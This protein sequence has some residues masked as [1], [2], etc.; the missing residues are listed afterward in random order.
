LSEPD[1]DATASLPIGS[2]TVNEFRP[3]ERLGNRYVVVQFVA[4]GGMGEVY[5]VIDEHLQGKHIAIKTL[6]RELAS[7]PEMRARFEREVL[8]AREVTHRAVCPTWDLIR[9]DRPT[10][11]V[12]C[13]SMKL[14]RGESLSSRLRRQGPMTPDAALLIARQMAAGLDA[15]HDAGVIHRD[16]K[17]GNVILEGQGTDTAAT[18]TDFGLSRIYNSDSTIGGIGQ[19]AGTRGYIAPE[20]YAGRTASPASDV[21]GFGVVLFEMLTGQQPLDCRGEPDLSVL[22]APDGWK[23]AIAGCLVTDPRERFQSAGEAIDLLESLETRRRPAKRGRQSTARRARP[24]LLLAGAL[25]LSGALFWFAPRA[26]DILHPLPLHRFV[27]LGSAPSSDP[28][29]SAMVG[30]ILDGMHDRLVRAESQVKDVLI[31]GTAELVRNEDP[32]T[33]GANLMLSVSLGGEGTMARLQLID[34]SSHKVLRT[35]QAPID[36]FQ[37]GGAPGAAA[38]IAAKMLGIPIAAEHLKDENELAGL[39]ASSYQIFTAAEELRRQPN[40]AGLDASIEKYQRVLEVSPRFAL[41]YAK[42][43][44]AYTRK[45]QLTHDSAALS[46]AGNNAELAIRRNPESATAVLSQALVFLYSGRAPQAL[47]ALATVLRLDPAN[48]EVLLYQATAYRDL[49]RPKDEE[50]TCRLIIRER[51]NYYRAYNALGMVLY[52]AGRYRESLIAFQQATQIA[53]REAL[54]FANLGLAYSLLGSKAEASAAF[55]ASLERAPSE[56]AWLNLG[57]IAFEEGNYRTAL[58]YFEKARDLKPTDDLAWRNIADCYAILGDRKAML[59]NYAKAADVLGDLL[60]TNPKRGPDWVTMA[61]YQAKLGYR[62]EA[63]S[64]LRSAETAGASS[65]QAQFT[66]AQALAVLGRKEEAMEILADCVGQGLSPAE[67]NLALDLKGIRE[68]PAW[69]AR[70]RRTASSASRQ[71]TQEPRKQKESFK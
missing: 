18:I 48:P 31:I 34:L 10:G 69:L 2:M 3:G 66:K 15:A 25:A 4:R 57:N 58:D 49:D 61:F 17:P 45:Y 14:L 29:Q 23:R 37:P 65:L 42:I 33:M 63:E 59:E 26:D 40:D 70:I 13:L 27:A 71:G 32:Q 7:D 24:Y 68:D 52:R 62:A 36:R 30:I 47:G 53:P 64:A 67:I 39:P 51:P 38:A 1:Q 12:L 55:H 21:Y 8:V 28:K 44:L 22:D 56:L 46:V 20:L 11:K 9:V 43:A 16:F 60:R 35:A 19:V 54:P 6:R 50:N 41:G 5:E